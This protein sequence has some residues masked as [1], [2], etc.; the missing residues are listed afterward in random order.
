MVRLRVKEISKQKGISMGKL[1]RASDISYRTIQRIY[2]D[3]TYI[4]TIPTLEKIARVLGVST[5]DLLED[6]PDDTSTT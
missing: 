4:P 1:S 6:I 3:P 2:N 5:G